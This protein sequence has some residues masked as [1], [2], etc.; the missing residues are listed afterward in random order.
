MYSCTILYC[1]PESHLVRLQR[2]LF[3]L[4]LLFCPPA[5]RERLSE[6]QRLLREDPRR[7]ETQQRD[8]GEETPGQWPTGT[9]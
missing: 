5:G 8:A 1:A 2:E 4:G 3:I 9:T 7:S 6:A